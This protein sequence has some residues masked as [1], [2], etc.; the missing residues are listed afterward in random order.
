MCLEM[1]LWEVDL[2][3]EVMRVRPWGEMILVFSQG[4]EGPFFRF[5]L[6]NH[7]ETLTVHCSDGC[8]SR[9]PGLYSQHPHDGSQTS[10]TPTFSS[11]GSITLP[12]S[13]GAAYTLINRQTWRSNTQ[14]WMFERKHFKENK[15]T[16]LA[17]WP[18]NSPSRTMRKSVLYKELASWY[19][20]TAPDLRYNTPTNNRCVLL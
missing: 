13:A 14:I 17:C 9:G 6:E 18:R 8:S 4:E 11:R 16:T 20:I 19:F 5:F 12:T 1:R 15:L 10:V 2:D 3:D 7:T